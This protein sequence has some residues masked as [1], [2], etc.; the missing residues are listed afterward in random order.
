MTLAPSEEAET[1]VIG[2]GININWADASGYLRYHDMMDAEWITHFRFEAVEGAGMRVKVTRIGRLSGPRW[3][4]GV[5]E[6]KYSP[7]EPAGLL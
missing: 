7:E 3:R 5:G 6:P 1:R 4:W 2:Q